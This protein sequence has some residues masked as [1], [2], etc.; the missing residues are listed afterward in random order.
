[1]LFKKQCTVSVYSLNYKGHFVFFDSFSQ[2]D[3]RARQLSQSVPC[4]LDHRLR[5]MIFIS[6]QV[7]ESIRK[8]EGDPTEIFS[9][10]STF[11]INIA[12]LST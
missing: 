9:D 3:A 2:C 1:M 11:L 4:N 6:K 7:W 10:N 12:Q 8:S 5:L